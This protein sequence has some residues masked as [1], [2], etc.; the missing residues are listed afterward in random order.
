MTGGLA[1]LERVVV[2]ERPADGRDKSHLTFVVPMAAWPCGSGL[3]EWVGGVSWR[4]E[5]A[6]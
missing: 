2:G 5:L 1:A 6:E 3:A 4:S